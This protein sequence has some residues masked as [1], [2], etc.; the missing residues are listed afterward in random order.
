MPQRQNRLIP[1]TK[2]GKLKVRKFLL[3]HP[4]WNTFDLSKP[5]HILQVWSS[6]MWYRL[7]LPKI[8]QLRSWSKRNRQQKQRE[9]TRQISTA[10]GYAKIS[11]LLSFTPVQWKLDERDW[12]CFKEFQGKKALTFTLSQNCVQNS[13]WPVVRGN[14]QYFLVPWPIVVHSIR[15]PSD[16]FAHLW[17]HPQQAYAIVETNH[18]PSSGIA[19][20][21]HPPAT[22]FGC[23]G[24]NPLKF[25]M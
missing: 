6:A 7:L 12:F 23:G 4:T 9:F 5:A 10:K 15:A 14:V 19:F 18:S 22:S 3:N 1:L 2:N 20:Q 21:K 24:T 8:W 11:T 17:L 16:S 13:Y 25:A